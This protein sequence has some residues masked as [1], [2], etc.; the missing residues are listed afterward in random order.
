MTAVDWAPYI[1]ARTLG[2]GSDPG[3]SRMVSW[4]PMV[5]RRVLIRTVAGDILVVAGI[6]PSAMR[7]VRVLDTTM[8]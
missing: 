5:L 3:G 8:N 7:V 1:R 2:G 6:T 4:S